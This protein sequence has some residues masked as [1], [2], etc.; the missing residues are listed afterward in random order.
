MSKNIEILKLWWLINSASSRRDAKE[1]KLITHCYCP[2]LKE[3]Q[4]HQKL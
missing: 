3:T 1:L 4:T 2:I